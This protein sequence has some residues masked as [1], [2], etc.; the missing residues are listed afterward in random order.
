M[1]VFSCHGRAPSARPRCFQIQFWGRFGPLGLGVEGKRVVNKARVG[2]P[3]LLVPV[4]FFLFLFVE[5]G[6]YT[7]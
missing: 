6:M 5:H 3:S 2:Q 1:A 7:V 4:N